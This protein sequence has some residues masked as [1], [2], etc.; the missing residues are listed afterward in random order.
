MPHRAEQE[1]L[2]TLYSLLK[3]KD[4][5][6]DVQT[7]TECCGSTIDFG[8]KTSPTGAFTRITSGPAFYVSAGYS[9]T[10]D[11]S[12]P[13]RIP[14]FSLL[15]QDL[16]SLSI[17]LAWSAPGGDYDTGKGDLNIFPPL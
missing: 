6:P 13:T 4:F 14:D 12:P 11:I 7:G 1:L 10:R 17:S 15:E 16:S 3:Y 9:L 8:N 5:L 2:S